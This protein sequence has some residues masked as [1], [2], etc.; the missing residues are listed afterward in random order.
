LSPYMLQCIG[1]VMVT[2]CGFIVSLNL[3]KDMYYRAFR[4]ATSWF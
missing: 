2:I 4:F 3:S 1:I